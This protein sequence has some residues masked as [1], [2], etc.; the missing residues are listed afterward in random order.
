[1]ASGSR[2]VPVWSRFCLRSNHVP[3]HVDGIVL[4]YHSLQIKLVSFQMNMCS[5]QN[6]RR[7]WTSPDEA[8][9]RARRVTV[10]VW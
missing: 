8:D 7:I 5:P 9:I 6:K 1:M 3:V 2:E 4:R 10:A